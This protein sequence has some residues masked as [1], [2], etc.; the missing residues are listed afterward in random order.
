MRT[1]TRFR[2]PPLA[3]TLLLGLSLPAAVR[4]E[5]PAEAT[6]GPAA[7]TE[8]ETY[9]DRLVTE[10]V[11]RELYRDRYWHI[12][13]HYKRNLFGLR[14]L[15]DDPGFFADPNGKH[16]PRAELEAT[17]RS[18]FQPLRAE[19]KHPV[20]RFAA[21]Y[22]WLK[23]AL[24]IDE[25]R[26]PVSACAAFED[27]VSQIRPE[28]VTLIFPT[29]HLNSPASMYGHT[30]LTVETATHSKLLAYAVNYSAVTP[31]GTFAPAY[32]V[33]GI[34]GGYPGYYSI[35]PYYAKLQEYSDVND[36]DIWEYPLNLDAAEIRRLLLHIYELDGIY[37]NYFFFGEN[38]SYGLLFLL[39]AARPSLHLTDQFGWW[40]IPL[41][42]IRAVRK[43][44]LILD[45]VYRPSKSTKVNYLAHSLPPR[46]RRQAWEL[47]TGRI[48]PAPALPPDAPREERIRVADLASEYV[49]YIYTKGELAKE[50]YQ[51]R[52]LRLLEARSSLGESEEPRY[53]IPPPGRPDDGH[54]SSRLALGAGVAREEP[55]LEVRL[56]PAY[57][58]LL[59]YGSGYKRGSQIV[60]LDGTGRYYWRREMARLEAVDLIDIVSIAPRSRFF[61]HTSWKVSTGFLRRNR[62]SPDDDFVWSLRPGAGLAW[63][64][65]AF[66]LFHALLEADLRV[67]GALPRSVALGGGAT[68][69]AIGE[70]TP[71]WKVQ[72][73]GRYLGYARGDEDRQLRVGLA[74]SVALYPNLGVIA[75]AERSAERGDP[76]WEARISGNVFF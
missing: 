48:E 27:L 19:E 43:N 38:C 71:R 52:F 3:W 63:E 16:D 58:E 40:V 9:A 14:S 5:E 10:A 42:T 24:G 74:Q 49:Q 73:L 65:R 75:A 60:F 53:P 1:V 55:F 67:G 21:R 18:F 68:V 23:E 50:T 26:L 25:S 37:S 66:G 32:I 34:F 51:A 4:A 2:L 64:T 54:R 33:K 70:L 45:A 61:K 29:S 12:L 22:Q 56:R 17:I 36:R 47:A 28:S 15:V 59:D 46:R 39:E 41:D 8:E 76:E 44:G 7:Q 31:G 30:L 20:C 11:R 6:T 13:L 62:Q 69:G 57:H 35:L 72:I